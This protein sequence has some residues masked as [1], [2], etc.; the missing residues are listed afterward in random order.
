MGPSPVSDPD[1]DPDLALFV[2]ELQEVDKNEK[3]NFFSSSILAYYF[4]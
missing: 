2:S 3:I 4:L 1:A